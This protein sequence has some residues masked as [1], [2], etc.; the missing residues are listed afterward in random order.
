MS[1]PREEYVEQAYFFKAMRER[2]LANLTAQELLPTLASELLSSTQLPMAVDFM[3]TELRH[4]GNMHTAMSRLPHYFTPFQT[5]VIE[6]A[7]AASGRFDMEIALAVLEREADYRTGDAL[8]SALFLYQFECLARNRLGYD[9]G[10]KAIAADH[11]VFS[12]DWR[13]WLD[14]VRRQ[15]GIIDFSDLIYVRSEYYAK[16]LQRRGLGLPPQEQV[17]FG[18]KE[19]KIAAAN[20]GKDP[21]FM[22]SAFQRQLSYP[23]VPRAKLVDEQ[24]LTWPD[25]IRRFER[26]EFRVKL[27]EEENKGGIDLTR[28]YG[29]GSLPD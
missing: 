5:F 29:P 6:T 10:L 12:P 9:R 24:Q 25:L 21:M 2:M 22:F 11:G 23:A 8:P 7:E 15:I 17:L 28:L 4:T 18:E 13:Q 14:Y 20:R 1:L 26:L 16:D 27:L 19:G 3:A